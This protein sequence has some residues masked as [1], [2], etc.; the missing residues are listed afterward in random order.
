M[1]VMGKGE[2]YCA[3]DGDKCCKCGRVLAFPYMAWD[4][5]DQ[6]PNEYS[7]IFICGQCCEWIAHGFCADLQNIV[8]VRALQRMGFYEG[9]KRAAVSGGFLYRTET[10]KQ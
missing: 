6:T 8:K 10:S 3:G 5:W 1:I 7:R 4:G 2:F 9:S